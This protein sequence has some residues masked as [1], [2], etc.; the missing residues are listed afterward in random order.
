MQSLNYVSEGI[1]DL[2]PNELDLSRPLKLSQQILR[3][4]TVQIKPALDTVKGI[5]SSNIGNVT[6]FTLSDPSAWV[7]TQSMVL[8]LTVGNVQLSAARPGTSQSTS[9]CFLDGPYAVLNRVNMNINGISINSPNEVSKHYTAKWLNEALTGHVLHDAINENVGCGKLV[10]LLAGTNGGGYVTAQAAYTDLCQSMGNIQ[11]S[12]AAPTNPPQNTPLGSFDA[13]GFSTFVNGTT[14]TFPVDPTVVGT[15][16][17]YQNSLMGDPTQKQITIPLSEVC[18]MLK[19]HRYLPLYLLKKLDVTLFYSSPQ[20]CFFTD[21]VGYT[22]AVV[23]PPAVAAIYTPIPITSY[24]ITN[25]S[26]SCDLLTCSDELNN[27][28]RMMAESEDQPIMIPFDDYT[29]VQNS[30]QYSGTARQ[31]QVQVSSANVKSLLFY[32]QS[33]LVAGAQNAWSNSNFHYLGLN[34]FQIQAGNKMFPQSPLMTCKDIMSYNSRSRGTL[35]NQLSSFVC[36]NPWI[37]HASEVAPNGAGGIGLPS[38]F[39]SFFVYTNFENI[40]NEDPDVIRNALNMKDSNSTITVKW[41]EN[42]DNDGTTG[43]LATAIQASILG[44]TA[45]GQQYTAYALVCYQ[46]VLIIKKGMIE[47]I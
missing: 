43:P 16:Y 29:V 47:V 32:Q 41:V 2:L 26:M 15:G 7:D 31:L 36:Q 28:F 17:G 24:D 40:L 38:S 19:Q 18:P 9:I 4:E 39:T 6:Q 30:Y 22:A 13:L 35:G 12:S 37:A 14:S 11:Y 46:R 3:R 45:G 21:A 44:P 1:V 5:N 27:S 10:P 33:N 42:K 25:I 34:S 20:A 8:N 23:G